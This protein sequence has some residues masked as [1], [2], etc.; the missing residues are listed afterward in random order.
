[1]LKRLLCDARFSLDIEVKGPLLIKAGDGGL[2]G[3]DMSFVRTH[4]Y[5]KETMHPYLPGPSLK[6][7]FRSHLE[8][9]ARTLRGDITPV[10]LPYLF[11]PGSPE[12][13]CGKR[14]D[15]KTARPEVYR[16]QCLACRML[17]SLEFKGRVA[18]DDA[19]SPDPA[20]I[21][22]EVRDGVAIDRKTGGAAPRAKYDLEVVTAG[23]FRTSI[24]MTNFE[25]WQLGALGLVLTDLVDE[26]L[27]FGTGTS[28]GLGHVK[29]TVTAAELR[30]P[31]THDGR[32]VGIERLADEATRRD[33]G[34]FAAPG[35]AP[36]LPAAEQVG[37]WNVHRLEADAIKP[38][39][40]AG[41]DQ[42]VAFMKTYQW[43]GGAA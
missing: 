7:V 32:F 43:N 14:F 10:C 25:A 38:V 30:Y 15:K 34:L 16:K 1:M 9:I 41:R 36:T 40:D 17:G 31:A 4:A 37:I 19:Y 11:E 18:I 23:V 39:M 3:P 21:R 33:Y 20:G 8:R 5:G 22:L 26:R 2:V 12:C 13:S 6:G 27:R 28:R 29:G 35:E 24:L 42:F